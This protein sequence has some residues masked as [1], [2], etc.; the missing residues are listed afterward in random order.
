MGRRGR[1]RSAWCA[2]LHASILMEFEIA[3]AASV[4]IT[5]SVLRQMA[6]SLILK[7]DAHAP[8]ASTVM[9]KGVP[10]RE[11]VTHRGIQAFMNR[12]DLVMRK[13]TGKLAVSPEKQLLI[14]K[15]VAFHLGALKRG[16]DSCELNKYFIEN[17]D[18]IHFIFNLDNGRTI[19]LKCDNHV[20]YAD[21]VS[22]ERGLQ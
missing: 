22:G 1:R 9:E 6:V 3:R 18:E 7:A 15:S 20:R 12:H 11:K 16:F 8:F 13:Q 19:G 4:N 2:A 10:I 5:P 14:E 17:A 21:V